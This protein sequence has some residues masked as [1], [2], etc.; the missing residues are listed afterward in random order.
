M[1]TDLRKT[2]DDNITNGAAIKPIYTLSSYHYWIKRN[3]HLFNNGKYNL[4]QTNIS[5]SLVVI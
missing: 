3:F 5:T 4:T 2:E 1:W